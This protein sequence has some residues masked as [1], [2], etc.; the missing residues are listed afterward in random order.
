[1]RLKLAIARFT[2]VVAGL[3]PETIAL[4]MAA[5]IVL[6]LFPMWGVPT[7][8]CALA[9]FLPRT[10]LPA[11]MAVNHLTSPLQLALFLPLSRAGAGIFGAPGG[12]PLHAIEGWLC[13][14]VPL[15]L[16]LYLILAYALRSRVNGCRGL[17]RARGKENAAASAAGSERTLSIR[18]GIS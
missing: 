8:L 6:G 4:C 14:C 16:P 12:L 15:G 11:L 2:G 7:L 18:L 3:A 17:W 5:G 1:M 9:G 13:V 10:N